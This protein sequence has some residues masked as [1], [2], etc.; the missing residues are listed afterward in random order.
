MWALGAP[1]GLVLVLVASCG[2]MGFEESSAAAT[3][4]AVTTIGDYVD[5]VLADAPSAYWRFD[6]DTDLEQPLDSAGSMQAVFVG[7]VA[8]A[9][10][11]VGQA[12]VF[13]GTTTRLKA[14]DHFAFDGK[15]PF[16][17]EMWV[18][19]TD[20]EDQVRFLVSRESSAGPVDGYALYSSPDFTQG[21]REIDGGEG[22]YA[23]APALIDEVW[24]HVAF[25]Y[26]GT[27][28]R[29]Y[30][31]GAQAGAGAPADRSIPA[32]VG[33]LVF[34]DRPASTA[35]P[36]LGLL[37]EIAVYDRALD[38]RRIAAHAAAR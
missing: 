19:S 14:G 37:D 6:D 27:R 8:R 18:M 20:T 1:A 29:L 33:S 38:P 32:G 24:T 7:T 3:G 10:G 30:L 28:T 22:D 2:R 11:M 23:D 15:S 16:T 25:A 35:K 13:D 21:M 17:Y 5:E 9:P 34:G 31:D 12:A 36:F 26:D 4:S